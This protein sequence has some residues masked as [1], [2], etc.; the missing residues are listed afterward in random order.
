MRLQ[1]Y[2]DLAQIVMATATLAGVLMSIWLSTKALREVQLDRKLR[3]SPFLAFEPGGHSLPVEFVKAGRRVPGMNPEYVEKVFAD[4]S[5]NAESVRLRSKEGKLCKYGTLKN[6]GLG[7]ALQTEITWTPKAIKIGREDFT[8]N[9]D[10]LEEPIYGKIFNTMPADP[11]HLAPSGEGQLTRLPT[12]VEKDCDK[13]IT[14]VRGALDICCQDVFG[15]KH[16]SYQKFRLATHYTDHEP[17]IIITFGDM[18]INF[19]DEFF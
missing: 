4:L 9:D 7:P 6:Y 5:S 16:N 11:T 3:L 13:K 1:I 2:S 17:Y 18:L 14:E 8:I 19:S 12:F 10:K 15:E